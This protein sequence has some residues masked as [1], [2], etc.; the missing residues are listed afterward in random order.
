LAEYQRRRQALEQR[1]HA[2]GMQAGQLEA[3]VDRQAELAGWAASAADF[4]RRIRAGLAGADFAQKCQLV[5]LLID[6]VLVTDDEVEI[7]YV[8]PLSPGSERVRF[9]HLR[10]DYFDQVAI[11]VDP[12]WA[13]DWGF[14]LLWRDHRSGSEIPDMFAEGMARIAT[15]GD[16]PAR[17]TGQGIQQGQGLRQL[18]RLPPGRPGTRWPGRPR[19][20]PRRLWCHSRH[21]NGQAPQP[22]PVA[23]GR[24]LARSARRLLMGTDAGAVEEGHAE[25]DA[26]LL[27]ENQ[28]A[29]PDTQARPADE[30]LGRHPPGPGLGGQGAPLGAI[31][32]SPQD[33]ADG[34]PQVA[35]WHLGVW[36]AG[37][38]QGP[39]HRPLGIRHHH[40]PSP[41][42]KAAETADQPSGSDANG[43]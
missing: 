32:V 34:S 30:G 7:R 5:E 8:L 42:A 3:Q 1:L 21:E 28:Q 11:V 37:F 2:L 19:R 38:D 12:A 4:C 22:S 6:R 17:H 31:R 9:C 14:V 13:S 25:L 29:L 27:G 36:P 15:V 43:P 18:V 20:R 40:R 16:D 24:P 39:E 26:A 35:R 41:S 23:S 33:R 10:K